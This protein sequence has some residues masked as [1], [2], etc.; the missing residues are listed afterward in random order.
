MIINKV[1]IIAEA[2]VNHNGDFDKAIQLIDVAADA[3]A[4][5]VKFQ[6]F[7][8]KNLAS[9]NAQ[10]VVYQKENT[11]SEGSQLEMLKRLEIPI[12]WYP[13]LL[14]RCKEK[15]I[16][17]L[18]TGFDTE[19][20]D[21][22]DNMGQKLFK[23][24]SGELTHKTLLRKIAKKNKPVIIS[25]GMASM[26]EIKEALDIFFKE[27]MSKEKI[28]VLHCTTSY[29][30]P[31]SEVNLY[32][33]K[34]IQKELGLKVGY[35]DHTLGIEV[36]LAATALGAS[37]IEKHIT[38]DKTLPG[39]DHKASLEPKEL[40]NLVKQIRSVTIA[41]SGNG[42]KTP[43]PTE[44]RNRKHIR[45]SLFYASNYK[46]GKTLSEND[47]L[48]LRPEG[49][50]SPMIIDDLIGKTLEQA[51]DIYQPVNRNHFL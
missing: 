4:D 14:S 36:S 42:Q 37:V 22:L 51:V 23:I 24:P 5:F 28:T 19:S 44:L 13:K 47:F 9:I 12:D 15:N 33:M 26:G 16:N 38:L 30:C 27:G 45:K 46:K 6:T 18:S 10:K 17:F 48:A 8:A 41:I 31:L 49:I 21:L 7:K 2:G 35:S 43:S 40:F 50:C 1:L 32:A 29:P 20:I 34:A 11:K 25:T 39:P 3:G